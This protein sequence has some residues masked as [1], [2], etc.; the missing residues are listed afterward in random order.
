MCCSDLS[1]LGGGTFLFAPPLDPYRKTLS[2][3][4]YLTDFGVDIGLSYLPNILNAS[5]VKV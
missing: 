3:I 1:G 2:F 5:S 4:P